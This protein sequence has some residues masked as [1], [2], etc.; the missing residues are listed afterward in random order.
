MYNDSLHPLQRRYAS[1]DSNVISLPAGFRRHLVGRTLINVFHC[2]TAEI[3]FVGE[4][5]IIQTFS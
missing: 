4:L 1:G 5:V 3:C 2:D